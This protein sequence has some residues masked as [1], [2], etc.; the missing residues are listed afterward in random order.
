MNVNTAQKI[1]QQLTANGWTEEKANP[2]V[3][4][5]NTCCVRNTAEQKILSHIALAGHQK[6]KNKN[7]IIAVIGCLSAK[8]GVKLKKSRPYIDIILGTDDALSVIDKI[9]EK[10]NIEYKRIPNKNSGQRDIAYIDITY[11]CDN[12]CSYCIVP[13][14]RGHLRCR[15][16]PEIIAE[17]NSAAGTAKTIF[18]LGQNVNEYYD[19]ATQ[20]AFPELLQ[21]LC[22]KDGSFKI[23]FLSSHPK[24]FSRELIDVIAAEEKICKDI[25]L[26]IQSGCDKILKLMNRKYT[27]AD[28]INIINNLRAKIPNVKITTDI[29]CGFPTETED[30]FN[31]TY[32]TVKKI[33]FNAAYIFPYSKRSGTAADKM[34]GQVPFEI[35]KARATKLIELLRT[36]S[37]NGGN[38]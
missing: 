10:L 30:D 18:L 31:E 36:M 4:I 26:P 34:D 21:L 17:F 2:D 23:N 28:Y 8:D 5:F 38:E 22:K 24:D 29:I 14:V 37:Y 13:F 35:K 16:L 25:H 19:E 15:P 32:N 6:E 20:T 12:Y 33:K 27:V 3:I 7:L 11:G 1:S 9:Y